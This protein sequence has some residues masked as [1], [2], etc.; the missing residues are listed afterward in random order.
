MDWAI[1]N[2]SGVSSPI[3]AYLPLQ[4]TIFLQ[5]IT[6]IRV[7]IIMTFVG[8][9]GGLFLTFGKIAGY[10]TYSGTREF[11]DWGNRM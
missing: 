9:S 6:G 8:C 4:F 3:V 7:T 10:R 1:L 5:A 2:T 11:P